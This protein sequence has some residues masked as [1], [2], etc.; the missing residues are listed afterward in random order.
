MPELLE[1]ETTVA[2]NKKIDK[3]VI[4]EII[5]CHPDVLFELWRF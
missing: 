2:L 1:V 4:S 3:M 5:V